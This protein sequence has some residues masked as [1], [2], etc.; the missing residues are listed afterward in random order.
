MFAFQ[1]ANG[2]VSPA[3]T[4][5]DYRR[6][7]VEYGSELEMVF[8][9][10]LNVLEVD[11]HGKPTNEEHAQHRA[12]QWIQSYVDPT[13]EPDPPLEPWECELH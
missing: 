5:V 11:E 7:L 9:V 4:D 12:A 13:Y 6:D 3:L 8:A 2:T 10:F 1:V